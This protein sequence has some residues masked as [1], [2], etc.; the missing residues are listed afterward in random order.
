MSTPFKTRP[1]TKIV[2]RK[3]PGRP[4]V[5]VEVGVNRGENAKNMLNN[6]KIKKLYL[7]DYWHDY[8]GC[9]W[10]NYKEGVRFT[11]RDYVSNYE[12][13]LENLKSFSD[14]TI[15]IREKSMDAVG[16]IRGLVDFV[17]IDCKHF[18]YDFVMSD[19]LAY[20]PLVKVGGF[21]G[22]HDFGV[23]KTT[24][25]GYAVMDFAREFDIPLTTN[26][27]DWWFRVEDNF[28]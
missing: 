6:L 28:L 12:F 26:G 23:N 8:K 3:C 1:F 5:G 21:L 13:C 4:L 14:R 22:G 10:H 15:F 7:V 11:E 19:I 17:Y 25:V 24:V 16:F 18:P 2:G 20:F 27:V 9:D